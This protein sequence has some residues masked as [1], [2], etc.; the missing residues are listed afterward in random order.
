MTG[1]ILTSLKEN[2]DLIG[3]VHIAGVPGQHEP[4]EGEVNYP[5]V[6]RKLTEMGYKEYFGLEYYPFKEIEVSLEETI[7]YLSGVSGF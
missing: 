5:F 4:S 7:N 1:N 2:I 3:H 6:L